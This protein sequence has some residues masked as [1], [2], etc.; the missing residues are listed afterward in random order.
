MGK[1]EI[2]HNEQFLLFP[3]CLLLNQI[4]VSS[5][6]HIFDFMSLFAAELE[7]PEIGISEKGWTINVTFQ[8]HSA[9]KDTELRWDFR[10]ASLEKW[11]N[12]K[13]ICNAEFQTDRDSNISDNNIEK[14]L[15]FF[16]NKHKSVLDGTM[17]KTISSKSNKAEVPWWSDK[18]TTA[19]KK[20][21]N[22]R[23]RMR[24]RNTQLGIYVNRL[25]KRHNTH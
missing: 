13:K 1:W 10:K 4:I 24:S 5:F 8:R 20:G 9:I 12:F 3:Q 14:W 23:K 15:E 25:E 16:Y 17:P 21:E 2:A 11:D 18:C 22:L 19:I 6:V 7:K